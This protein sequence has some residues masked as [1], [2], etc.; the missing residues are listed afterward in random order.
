MQ[1]QKVVLRQRACAAP[2]RAVWVL[3]PL[4][5]SA[6]ATYDP[7]WGPAEVTNY[8]RPAQFSTAR[9]QRH[10]IKTP[11][12]PFAVCRRNRLSL[13]DAMEL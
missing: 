11:Y 9:S 2:Y 10:N 4:T 1:Q 3:A 7:A 8:S 12:K 6:Y 5:V 13:L